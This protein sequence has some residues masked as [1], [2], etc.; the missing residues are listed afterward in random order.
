[1]IGSESE[2]GRRQSL[3]PVTWTYYVRPSNLPNSTRCSQPALEECAEVD[4]M[5]SAADRRLRHHSCCKHL[6]H[7]PFPSIG[8]E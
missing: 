5:N 1:M 7:T 6:T 4:L 2:I 3:D 8:R